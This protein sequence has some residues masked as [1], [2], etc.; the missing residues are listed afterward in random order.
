MD[1]NFNCFV[2]NLVELVFKF[3]DFIE[4]F[5]DEDLELSFGDRIFILLSKGIVVFF[6]FS[7]IL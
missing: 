2:E 3:W 4:N 1:E 5:E 7:Y 6:N